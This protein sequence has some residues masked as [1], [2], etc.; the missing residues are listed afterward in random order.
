MA[1]LAVPGRPTQGLHCW[2]NAIVIVYTR[3]CVCLDLEPLII[4]AVATPGGQEEVGQPNSICPCVATIIGI[5]GAATSLIEIV[6]LEVE[7]P[8]VAPGQVECRHAPEHPVSI[9]K[10]CQNWWKDSARIDGIA[11]PSIAILPPLIVGNIGA[12]VTKDNRS[13]AYLTGSVILSDC[14]GMGE[15]WARTA[16]I[17]LQVVQQTIAIVH[18]EAREVVVA[19]EGGVVVGRDTCPGLGAGAVSYADHCRQET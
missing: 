13:V 18:S 1:S 4:T 3:D 17:C 6:A 15:W 10:P 8:G 14:E 9:L 16:Y 12:L 11:D 2:V 7:I 5:D 19:G